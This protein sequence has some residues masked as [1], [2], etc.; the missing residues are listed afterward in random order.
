VVILNDYSARILLFS[1]IT[2]WLLLQLSNANG[3]KSVGEFTGAIGH[4]ICLQWHWYVDYK[5]NN[6]L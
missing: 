3:T 2:C 5:C 4:C 1:G 6:C